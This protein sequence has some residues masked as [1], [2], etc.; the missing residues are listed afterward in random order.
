MS[1]GFF[2]IYLFVNTKEKR[3]LWRDIFK[4]SIE[5]LF[6]YIEHKKDPFFVEKISFQVD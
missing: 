3:S 1:I 6:F 4:G 2:F 5:I